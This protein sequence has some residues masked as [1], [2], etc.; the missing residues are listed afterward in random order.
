MAQK[1]GARIGGWAASIGGAN[2][3]YV[4]FVVS[5][6]VLIVTLSVLDPGYGPGE[7]PQFSGLAAPLFWV[8][9]WVGFIGG[10]AILMVSLVFFAVSAVLAIVALVRGRSAAKPLIGCALPILVVAVG[11]LAYAA[12]MMIAHRQTDRQRRNR[13]DVGLWDG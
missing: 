7:G 12:T 11:W 10:G 1:C 8:V 6:I 5:L 9:F 13:A 3:G 2:I 4:V